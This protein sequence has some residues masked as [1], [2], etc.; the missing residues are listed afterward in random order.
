MSIFSYM[1]IK[2]EMDRYLRLAVKELMRHVDGLVIYDDRSDDLTTENMREICGLGNVTF[3]IRDWLSFSFL[4]N[5]AEFRQDAW[6]LME[7]AFRPRQDD[8][9]LTL[10]ADEF[11]RSSLPLRQICSE[12]SPE[13]QALRCRVHEMWG[14]GDDD[15]IRVDGFW[16]TI[17]ATRLC[18][19]DPGARFRTVD[20][21]GR[22][23]PMGR[24]S[25]PEVG[26][27]DKDSRFDILHYGYASAEDREIKYRRYSARQGHTPRHVRSIIEPPILAPLQGVG[28]AA[29]T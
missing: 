18:R 3:M 23:L 28:Y 12:T 2:N 27:T 9:I 5:E 1:V 7:K 6:T 26:R 17:E 20:S 14:T 8:W 19:Y 11:L 29:I 10:D 4:E 22:R 24:G 15:Q 25:L 13:V 21:E 16:P